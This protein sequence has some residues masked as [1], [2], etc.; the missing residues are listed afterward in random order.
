MSVLFAC[1][2]CGSPAVEPPRAFV[3]SAAVR[4]RRCGQLLGTWGALKQRTERL[5]RTELRR[6]P[7]R[8]W[9]CSSDPLP[10]MRGDGQTGSGAGETSRRSQGCLSISERQSDVGTEPN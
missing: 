3:D 9:T 4:C 8:G 6:E 2:A 5:I 10:S 1:G 7:T